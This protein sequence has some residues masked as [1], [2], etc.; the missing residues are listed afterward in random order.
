[1]PIVTPLPT[2]LTKEHRLEHNMLVGHH[3]ALALSYNQLA[4]KSWLPWVRSR[5]MRKAREATEH[6]NELLTQYRNMWKSMT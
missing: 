1:M 5:Y 4:S 2:R 6:A 3:L